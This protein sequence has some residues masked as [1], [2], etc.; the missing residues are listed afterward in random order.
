VLLGKPALLAASHTSWEMRRGDLTSTSV[1]QKSWFAAGA[2]FPIFLFEMPAWQAGI[3]TY[4]VA[5]CPI[6]KMGS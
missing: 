3:P 6:L 2:A 5:L 4:L 1:H